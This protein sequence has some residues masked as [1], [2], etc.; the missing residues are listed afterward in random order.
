MTFWE[1]YWC[2]IAIFL[3]GGV[4]LLGMLLSS[5]P[6]NWPAASTTAIAAED[7]GATYYDVSAVWRHGGYTVAW[8]IYDPVLG[9][10]CII[11]ND[12]GMVCYDSD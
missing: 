11:A 7:D 9:K 10:V 2:P 4:L 3:V 12:Y 6:A 8:R 5:I 1:R